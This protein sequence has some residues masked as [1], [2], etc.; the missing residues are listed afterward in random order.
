[1][2]SRTKQGD[3]HWHKQVIMLCIFQGDNVYLNGEKLSKRFTV[4]YIAFISQ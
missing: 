1:M 4:L 2:R 3:D